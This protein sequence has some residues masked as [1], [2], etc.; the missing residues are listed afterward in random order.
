MKARWDVSGNGDG[1]MVA[2]NDDPDQY[3]LTERRFINSSVKANFLQENS[4]VVMYLWEKAKEHN[5]LSTVYQ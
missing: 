1:S 5:F 3:D 4:S 2:K